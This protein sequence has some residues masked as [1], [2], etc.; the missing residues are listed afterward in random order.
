VT[1]RA[2][3]LRYARALFDVVLKEGSAGTIEQVQRELAQFADLVASSAP[4]TQTFDNPAIPAALKRAVVQALLE[5]SG[6]VTPAMGKLLLLLADRD[7]LPLLS[8]VAVAY[9]E[10][11][12]DFQKVIRGVVTTAVPLLEDRLRALQQGLSEAT[13]RTVLLDTRVDA[14][15]IGGVV[16][17]LGSTVYDGSVTTQLLRMRRTLIEGAQ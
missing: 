13:G 3:A 10:R 12:Q 4:L 14:S 17:R 15:I 7:R 16:T 5:R 6:A 9:R 8:G 1:S 11:V 2:A